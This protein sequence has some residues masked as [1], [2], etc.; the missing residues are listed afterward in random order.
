MEFMDCAQNPM[1][2]GSMSL[3]VRTCTSWRGCCTRRLGGTLHT[4]KKDQWLKKWYRM[5]YLTLWTCSLSIYVSTVQKQLRL[6]HLNSFYVVFQFPSDIPIDRPSTALCTKLQHP[7][8]RLS[9]KICSST[10]PNWAVPQEPAWEKVD[11]EQKLENIPLFTLT[12]FDSTYLHWFYSGSCT[13]V[14]ILDIHLSN[15]LVS[16]LSRCSGKMS[17]PVVKHHGAC[18]P[19]SS[20]LVGVNAA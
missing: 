17:Y 13:D 11:A 18:I 20:H 8:L 3:W 5:V 10:A 16:P 12:W 19:S 7:M 6:Q 2:L 14:Q 4:Y 9:E 15:L 1:V